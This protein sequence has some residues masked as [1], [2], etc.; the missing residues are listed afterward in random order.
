MKNIKNYNFVAIFLEPLYNQ[1]SDK[2]TDKNRISL[3][4]AKDVKLWKTHSISVS[5]KTMVW[6]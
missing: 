1:P 6:K 4:E 3:Q 2:R 5:Q